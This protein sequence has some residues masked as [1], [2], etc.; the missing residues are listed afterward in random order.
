MKLLARVG[1]FVILSGVVVALFVA[2]FYV[3]MRT[4]FVGREVAVPALTGM[5][6]DDARATLNLSEL[7]LEQTAERYDDRVPKGHVQAQD[8]PA[9]STIKKNRKVRV[10]ISLGPLAVTIP[11]LRGQTLRSARIALQKGGLLVGFV[12]MTHDDDVLTDVVM[13]QHPLPP[14][15]SASG[16]G[17]EPLAE[18]VVASG[19]RPT[20]DLLV[21]RGKPESIYVMPDLAHRRLSEV[22]AFAK[23][24]G[25]RI[26]AVRREKSD[27]NQSGTI[28]KQ[29]PE[30]GYPVGRQEIISLVVSD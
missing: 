17:A 24:V 23:R 21:S 30:A 25:L 6:V 16:S 4:I 9:G 14:D 8:P 2:S 7:F 1:W 10:T 27:E 11:D 3:S 19:G 22:T 29:Y 20:M 15:P 13:A 5:S 28:I 26:G 12:T 18:P